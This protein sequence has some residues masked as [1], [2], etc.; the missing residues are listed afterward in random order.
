MENMDELNM[1]ESNPVGAEKK[2]FKSGIETLP[3]C[4][5]KIE[6]TQ[7]ANPQ[8]VAS[9]T[10]FFYQFE[11]AKGNVP[12]I[13]TNRHVVDGQDKLNFHF[14]ISDENGDRVLGP[15][16]PIGLET[17]GFPIIR[18]PNSDVDLACIPARPLLE[19]LSKTG[20][21]PHSLYL[22]EIHL[23]PSWLTDRLTAA[24]E[25]LMIGF[26]NGLMDT[27]NN[28]PV[29][30]KGILATHRFADYNGK[31]NF[32]VDIAAFGGSS[33]SPVFAYFYGMSP[34][35]DGMNL[36]SGSVYLIGVLHSGPTLSAIGEI[37]PVPIPTA[38]QVSRTNL[39]MHLGFCVRAELIEDMKPAV[40]GLL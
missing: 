35:E 15:S 40:E 17:A 25:A 30:R 5:V 20:H 36:G 33:G 39:M 9:G 4:V 2:P 29:T 38:T 26:P 7:T 12:V 32:V 1:D 23:P 21:K 3:Y 27:A 37:V 34:T 6:G 8:A 31:P 22:G 16:K 24:T 28:L 13:I 14:G 19:A 10:G 18:H 11:T